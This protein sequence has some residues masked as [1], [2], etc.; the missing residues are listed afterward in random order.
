MGSI[1]IDE[2][3]RYLNV[4]TR[5]ISTYI[6]QGIISYHKKQGSN[7]KYIKAEDLHDLRHAKEEETFSVKNYKELK[8]KVSRLEAQI[9]LLMRIIDTN[10]IELGITEESGKELFA[11]ALSTLDST[12]TEEHATAWLPVLMSL[13]EFDLEKI[14]KATNT[15][16]PWYPFLSLCVALIVYVTG[17]KHYATS[18]TLQSMHKELTE[19]RRRIRLSALI[20]IEG[21]G[22]MIEVDNLVT[23]R[24]DTVAEIVKKSL[25]LR[26]K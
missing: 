26:H 11:A 1:T 25:K 3:A 4:S 13:N 2:A 22:P 19:A 18:L 6:S 10:T 14:Q 21:K 15:D 24:P 5:T 7:R 12:L 23:T 8:A 17:N 20:Y 16:K 9:E